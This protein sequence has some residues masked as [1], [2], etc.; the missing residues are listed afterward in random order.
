[1]HNRVSRDFSN[2]AVAI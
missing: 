2:M 1:M